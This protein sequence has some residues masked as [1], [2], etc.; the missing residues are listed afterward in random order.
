MSDSEEINRKETSYLRKIIF[1]MPRLSTSLILGVESFSLFTMYF[2]GFGVNPILVT[3]GIAM[4]FVSIADPSDFTR[5]LYAEIERQRNRLI[6]RR[7][8]N[9]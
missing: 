4:G 2:L 5:I 9:S 7:K 1:G 8:R 3:S 6:F